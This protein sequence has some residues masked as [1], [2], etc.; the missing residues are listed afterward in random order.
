MTSMALS[1][2]ADRVYR[3]TTGKADDKAGNLEREQRLNACTTMRLSMS[4][5]DP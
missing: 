4:V 1:R 3:V 2:M 5:L